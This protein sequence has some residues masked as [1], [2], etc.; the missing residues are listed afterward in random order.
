MT[1]VLS[2][3][4]A[5]AHPHIRARG[6]LPEYG[7]VVQAG[8]APRLSASATRE[9]ATP[10]LPGA[11]NDEVFRE[12]LAAAGKYETEAEGEADGEGE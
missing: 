9:P 11:H 12:W 7:G 1:P 5:P 8:A 2:L 4:E 3:A 6:T 10:P